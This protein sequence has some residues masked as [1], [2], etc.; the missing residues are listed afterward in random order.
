M[1]TGVGGLSQSLAVTYSNNISAGTAAA[2]ASFAGDANH[3]G[4]ADSKN[5]TIDK[6]SLTI[7]AADKTKVYGDANPTLTGILVGL[8]PGDAIT[9]T[10]STVATTTSS[11]GN[12]AIVPAA[13]D[14]TPAKLANYTV[15]LNNGSLS[16]TKASLTIKADDKTKLVG[17]AN[18]SFTASNNGFKNG[19]TVSSLGGT[20]TFTT[21]ATT[22]SPVGLYPI[23][24]AGLT[25]SNYTIT[26]NT[27]N[28]AI[29]YRFD[30]F[31]QPIND[32]AHEQICGT[33]C[34]ISI[35]K[36]G[37]TIPV[38]FDLMRA[39]GTLIS[40]T[41]M[42]TFVGP[43]K[44]GATTAPID[45]SVYNVPATP[46]AAFTANGGHYQYNWSTKGLQAGFYY[47]IG[48]KLDDGTTQWVYIGL[49]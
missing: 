7:T 35:F 14:S 20:L 8:K 38:K 36:A 41:L 25:S 44:G 27:G 43:I 49:N 2:N 47:R 9:A 30:G 3:L 4:S 21:L 26:F 10:Y 24:P 29:V 15:T 12:Y 13:V 32:T 6:A 1:V 40:A 31:L 39:D 45:E 37:S 5:F 42:P 34:P 23:T 48:A 28:L 33:T 46:G 18:P 17:A 11:V 22:A 19:D 16:V